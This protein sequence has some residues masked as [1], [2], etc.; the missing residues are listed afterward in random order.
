[1]WFFDCSWHCTAICCYDK[2]TNSVTLSI[3]IG[4]TSVRKYINSMR[5]RW[6]ST[7]IKRMRERLKPGPFSSSPSSGLGARLTTGMQT[8]QVSRSGVSVTL[9]AS[10][11]HALTLRYTNLTPLSTNA[12]ACAKPHRLICMCSVQG[13]L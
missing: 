12:R 8:Y 5:K 3:N 9:F 6:N 11:S 10:H 13:A 4:V 7:A 2:S 1:M